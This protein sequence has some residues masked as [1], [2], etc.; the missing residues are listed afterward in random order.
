MYNCWSYQIVFTNHCMDFDITFS[1]QLARARP[2]FFLCHKLAPTIFL[3]SARAAVFALTIHNPSPKVCKLL[4]TRIVYYRTELLKVME[5]NKLVKFYDRSNLNLERESQQR[6]KEQRW[7]FWLGGRL[8]S[9]TSSSSPPSSPPRW[10]R[11]EQK[12]NLNGLNLKPANERFGL[13]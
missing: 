13:W 1:I 5:W 3:S 7:T 9:R 12:M 11:P 6:P 8:L 2:V 4:A 10:T